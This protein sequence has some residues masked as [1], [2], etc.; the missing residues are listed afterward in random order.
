[1]G[2]KAAKAES[3]RN[4][5]ENLERQAEKL[6]EENRAQLDFI[7]YVKQL[8]T[9]FDG[10]DDKMNIA[11]T[12]T[13]TLGELFKDQAACYDR[14]GSYLGGMKGGADAKELADRKAFIEYNVSQAIQKLREVCETPL[15]PLF[16][17]EFTLQMQSHSQENKPMLMNRVSPPQ[18]LKIVAYEFQRSMVNEIRI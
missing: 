3:L 5:H 10:I 15:L 18:Q 1:M 16:P 8:V 12:A 11:I 17:G 13:K 6:K 7:T 14:I 9:Q 4:A 2:V